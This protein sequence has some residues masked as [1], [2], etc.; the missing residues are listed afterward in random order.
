MIREGE[1]NSTT[2][3][4]LILMFAVIGL[5]SLQVLSLLGKT[6]SGNYLA[7]AVTNDQ[8]TTQKLT[9]AHLLPLQI[10]LNYIK[11]KKL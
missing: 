3:M 7:F 6:H 1:A 8:P 2:T 5:I 10:I 4:K 9:Y 11:L